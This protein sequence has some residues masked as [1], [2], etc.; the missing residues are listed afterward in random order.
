MEELKLNYKISG[1]LDF[2]EVDRDTTLRVFGEILVDRYVGKSIDKKYPLSSLGIE[3]HDILE[4]T[5]LLAVLLELTDEELNNEDQI[6]NCPYLIHQ[7]NSISEFFTQ[8]CLQWI[9]LYNQDFEL[10]QSRIKLN[11]I[12]RKERGFKELMVYDNCVL[13]YGDLLLDKVDVIS[14]KLTN[15][16]LNL[17]CLLGEDGDKSH[18]LRLPYSL[19]ARYHPDLLDKLRKIT[20]G[21]LIDT[22]IFPENILQIG[23]RSKYPNQNIA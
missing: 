14:E 19:K 22:G 11:L 13:E 7:G 17:L 4:H 12:K 21:E 10:L 20:V 9:Y 18:L 6:E 15:K 3:I 16:L 5:L 23:E 2:N 8:D 1:E